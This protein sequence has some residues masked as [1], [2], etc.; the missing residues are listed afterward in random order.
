MVKG[1]LSEQL[2]NLKVYYLN[3]RFMVDTIAQLKKDLNSS[4]LDLHLESSDPADVRAALEQLVRELL[5]HGTER[6]FAL[7]YRIDIAETKI[8]EFLHPDHPGDPITDIAQAMLDRELKKVII[9]NYLAK[10][11]D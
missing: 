3:E 4:G 8:A 5:E 11:A 10:R 2:R 1:E 9:R 7:L 6:L